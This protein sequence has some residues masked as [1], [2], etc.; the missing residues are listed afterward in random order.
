M[1]AGETAFKINYSWLYC[2]REI[3]CVLPTLIYPINE[4]VST[5]RRNMEETASL[6]KT[7]IICMKLIC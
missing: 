3:S 4:N 5:Q 2:E 7:I 6:N 1:S